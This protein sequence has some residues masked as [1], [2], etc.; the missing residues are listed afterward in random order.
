MK[1]HAYTALL[2]LDVQKDL[3]RSQTKVFREADLLSNLN[4]L[5]GKARAANVPVLFVQHCAE[6][7][8]IRGS[9]GWELHPE[10]NF[11]ESD[12]F[13]H[14]NHISAFE[15]TPLQ[16]ELKKRNIRRVIIGGLATQWCVQTA[17]QDAK[18]LGY[19]VVLA[20]DGHSNDDKNA[21]AIIQDW[22]QQLSAQG[23]VVIPT[24]EI[25]F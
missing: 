17:C 14:K 25:R 10:L 3:F 18:K 21:E 23:I 4:T 24:H 19:E 7:Y 2:I 22:N 1:D 6:T 16:D 8:L 5:I 12:T 9:E 15:E 11:T 20:S 13:I